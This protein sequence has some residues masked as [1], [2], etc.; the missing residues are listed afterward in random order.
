MASATVNENGIN[1][2]PNAVEAH[3]RPNMVFIGLESW[4]TLFTLE[5]DS[6]VV[7]Q[8]VATDTQVSKLSEALQSLSSDGKT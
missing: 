1:R 4:Y 5:R 3:R 6:S 8:T 2:T 7:D